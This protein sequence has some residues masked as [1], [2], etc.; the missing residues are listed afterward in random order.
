MERYSLSIIF[1]L[2]ISSQI[3]PNTKNIKESLSDEFIIAPETGTKI[4]LEEAESGHWVAHDNELRTVPETDLENLLT[5]DE[6]QA[7]IALNYLKENKDYKRTEL[8]DEQFDVFDNTNTLNNYDDWS[9]SNPF[10]FEN[11]I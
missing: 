5:E 1:F 4:T 11:G 3:L 8:T 2:Y 10:S 6:K 9:Y 7:E